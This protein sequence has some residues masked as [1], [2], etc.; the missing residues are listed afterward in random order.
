MPG[1]RGERGEREGEET[2]RGRGRVRRGRSEIEEEER[3][4]EGGRE[5]EGRVREKGL[6]YTV[7]VSGTDIVENVEHLSV[8]DVVHSLHVYILPPCTNV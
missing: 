6:R 4:R 8:D 1:E 7:M 3:E 2:E 5:R